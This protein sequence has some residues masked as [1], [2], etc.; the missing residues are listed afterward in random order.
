MATSIRYLA[1]EDFQLTAM[2]KKKQKQKQKEEKKNK[3]KSTEDWCS[4]GL[5]SSLCWLRFFFSKMN[6]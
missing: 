2:Q 3:R 4:S 6:Q 1:V 5:L